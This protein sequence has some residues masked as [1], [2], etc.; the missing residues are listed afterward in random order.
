MG[1][2]LHENHAEVD[3]WF[4]NR[5]IAR[6]GNEN[7]TDKSNRHF[8]SGLSKEWQSPTG[9]ET[10]IA[11]KEARTTHLTDE[12]EHPVEAFS[13]FIELAEVDITDKKD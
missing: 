10:R 6:R 5:M 13:D 11:R 3:E 1:N 7:P 9:S 4:L 2:I 12:S 8:S